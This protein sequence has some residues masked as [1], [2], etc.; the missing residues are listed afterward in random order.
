MA[1][2]EACASVPW[3]SLVQNRE[4]DINPGAY[5]VQIDFVNEA[6]VLHQVGD[7]CVR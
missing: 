1:Q 2:R 5:E 6:N 7:G 3:L 4:P